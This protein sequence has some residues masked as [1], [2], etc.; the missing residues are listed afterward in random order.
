MDAW[1]LAT[2]PAPDLVAAAATFADTVRVMLV[3]TADE[4]AAAGADLGGGAGQVVVVERAPQEPAEAYAIAVADDLAGRLA[5]RPAV[6][7]AGPGPTDRVLLGAVAGRLGCPIV[8]SVLTVDR[9]PGEDRPAIARRL[10]NGIAQATEMPQGTVCLVLAD[11]GTGSGSGTTATP[12]GQA[13][14]ERLAAAPLPLRVT[15]STPGAPAVD[16]RLAERVVG[17][18][19]GLAR[20]E[21]LPMMTDLATALGAALGCSRPLAEGL[22]WFPKSS[23]IGASGTHVRGGLYVAVGISGQLQHM[24]G[25]RGVDTIVAIN[26]DPEAPIVAESDYTILGDLYAIVPALTAAVRQARAGGAP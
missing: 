21:D 2:R 15:A 4:L 12:A 25:T 11:A 10:Y 14:V 22:D 9:A 26:N 5:D 8:T 16:L 20:A 17:V 3:A 6:V 13:P 19:R 1:I 7:I 24:V 18:G 23:Y